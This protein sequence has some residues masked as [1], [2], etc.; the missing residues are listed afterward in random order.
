MYLMRRLFNI[1]RILFWWPIRRIQFA[2][3]GWRSEVRSPLQLDNPGNIRIG[4][5]VRINRFCWLAAMPLCDEP[6]PVLEFGDGCVVGNFCHIYATSRITFGKNVLLADHVYISDNRHSYEDPE[7]PVRLQKI[8]QLAEVEI[9]DD[10]WIG[11]NVCV[12]GA[13]IGKHCV[14]GANSVVT[15]DI[16][17]FC[18][19][20]GVPARVIKRYDP[21]EKKWLRAE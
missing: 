11:E 21:N 13:K 5:G 9:G 18:V 16:P 2:S 12:M 3:F 14:V 1:L 17:D 4:R 8:R 19:A 15:R 6:H 10:S 20:A 7:T